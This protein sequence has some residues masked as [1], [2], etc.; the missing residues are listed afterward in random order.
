MAV[1]HHDHPHVVGQGQCRERPCRRRVVLLAE[2]EHLEPGAG[3]VEGV[4]ARDQPRQAGGL[5]VEGDQHRVEGQ[6]A[7]VEGRELGGVDRRRARA[8]PAGHED[9]TVEADHGAGDGDHGDERER[10][11]GRSQDHARHHREPDQDR[12]RAL[13]GRDDDV[14]RLVGTLGHRRRAGVQQDVGGVQA[15]R[16]L[17]DLGAVGEHDAD[18]P[19]QVPLQGVQ[20]H[21]LERPGHGDDDVLLGLGHGHRAQ[22]HGRRQRQ[23]Q[24][25]GGVRLDAVEADPLQ[26]VRLGQ[27]GDVDVLGDGAVRLEDLAERVSGAQVLPVGAL[28]LGVGDQT[29][30]QQHLPHPEAAATRERRLGPGAGPGIGVVDGVQDVARRVGDQPHRPGEPLGDHVLGERVVDVGGGHEQHAV[31]G[32]GVGQHPERAA[33]ALGEQVAHVGV[34]TG[35]QGRDGRGERG[36]GHVVALGPPRAGAGWRV[37]GVA[38]QRAHEARSG[39]FR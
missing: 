28:Q 21:R 9:G 31:V 23:P 34:D 32:H 2:Q 17:L 5:V 39:T 6:H 29:A 14:G 26:L 16:E 8:Q 3:V 36:G 12:R 27:D 10:G 7:L 35:G 37:C 4:Q 1:G 25:Q 30:A 18:R 24:G 11:R 38:E 13:T 19:C 15:Q 20:L 22:P 33:P